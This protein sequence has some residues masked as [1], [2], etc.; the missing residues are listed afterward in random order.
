MYKHSFHIDTNNQNASAFLLAF[1]RI[2]KNID[3]QITLYNLV[4]EPNFIVYSA[5]SCLVS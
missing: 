1:S 5:Q 2:G 4:M 3:V